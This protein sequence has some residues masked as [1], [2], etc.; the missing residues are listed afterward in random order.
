MDLQ[1]TAPA[2]TDVERATAAPAPNG[3]GHSVCPGS[4]ERVD[5]V[6]HGRRDPHQ[7]QFRTQDEAHCAESEELTF[8]GERA[9]RMDG[10]DPSQS[11][12]YLPK[13][14]DRSA[15]MFNATA[16]KP[17]RAPQQPTVRL[18]A[19]SV[20]TTV[21]STVP[22]REKPAAGERSGAQEHRPLPESIPRHR[23]F[24]IGAG[25]YS[26][27]LGSAKVATP[28]NLLKRQRKLPLITFAH[29]VEVKPWRF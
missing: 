1:V 22:E 25:V 11:D 27:V 24:R 21:K 20:E 2:F 16:N 29:S 15:V 5:R 23:V 26:A 17:A 8:C 28:G 13:A 7:Q 9:G 19:G 3:R 18:A 4:M 6:R 14:R 12:Q 10:G